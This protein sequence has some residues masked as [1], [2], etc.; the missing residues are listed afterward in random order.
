MI[1]IHPTV[2]ALLG[3]EPGTPVDGTMVIEVLAERAGEQRSAGCHCILVS[4]ARAEPC[5]FGRCKRL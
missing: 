3:L 1:N 4:R 2:M 5:F